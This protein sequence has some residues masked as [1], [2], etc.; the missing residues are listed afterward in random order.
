MAYR[1]I[2]NMETAK[3]WGD[4]QYAEPVRAELSHLNGVWK[5]TVKG[6]DIDVSDWVENDLIESTDMTLTKEGHACVKALGF[7]YLLD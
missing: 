1:A 7:G 5:L 3:G 6:I 4:V 2:K